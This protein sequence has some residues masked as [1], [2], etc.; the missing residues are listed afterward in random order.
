[1]YDIYIYICEVALNVYIHEDITE[2]NQALLESKRVADDMRRIIESP[3]E[4]CM[5]LLY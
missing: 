3:S 4:L 1:M 5:Y 2:L